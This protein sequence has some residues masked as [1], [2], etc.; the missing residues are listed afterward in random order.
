MHAVLPALRRGGFA[1]MGCFCF[2]NLGSLFSQIRHQFRHLIF[3]E[4]VAKRRHGL[5]SMR[6][7]A[8]DGFRLQL[9]ADGAQR[10]PIL[11]AP[12]RLTV[13]VNTAGA[14]KKLRP[15]RGLRS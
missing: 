3:C 4:Y 1:N 13:A 10:R 11:R 14:L 5:P 7:L 8:G 9:F 15:G 6:D 12:Q 2:R